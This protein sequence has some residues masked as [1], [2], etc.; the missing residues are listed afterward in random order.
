MKQLGLILS[1][2]RC[3]ECINGGSRL[4]C[5]EAKTKSNKRD[6]EGRAETVY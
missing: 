1:G 5:A 4:R 2:A 3:E 6:Q